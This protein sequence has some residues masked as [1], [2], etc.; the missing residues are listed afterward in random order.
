VALVVKINEE[1]NKMMGEKNV[2]LRKNVRERR[3]GRGGQ[4]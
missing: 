2:L 3:E 4:H 1:A